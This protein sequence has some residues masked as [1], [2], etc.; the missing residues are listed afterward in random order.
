MLV[1][2]LKNTPLW[3][4][5]LLAV[6]I[7]LGATQA[8]ARRVTARRAAVLPAVLVVL[9]LAGV[10]TTFPAA[11]VPVAAWVAGLALA[12]AAGASLV[13][14][15]GARWDAASGHFDVP[16]SLLPLALILSLF[17]IKYGVGVTLAMQP[18]L[19]RD[20]L[21]GACTGAAYGLFSGLFLA[22]AAS[23]RRLAGATRPVIA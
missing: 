2:I 6:L 12:L 23:L 4:W 7:A 15:R 16:G 17:V 1:Q 14:V 10:S 18:A 21:F 13:P 8:V 3:V 9:S 5:G 20:M 22:R 11:G 19:A